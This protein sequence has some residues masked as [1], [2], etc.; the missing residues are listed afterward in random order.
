MVFAGTIATRSRHLRDRVFFLVLSWFPLLCTSGFAQANVGQAAAPPLPLPLSVEWSEAIHPWGDHKLAAD[1]YAVL[2]KTK[3]FKLQFSNQTP[4]FLGISQFQGLPGGYRITEFALT[5]KW[6]TIHAFRSLGFNPRSVPAGQARSFTGAA[7]ELPKFIAGTNLSAYLLR[8]APAARARQPAGQTAAPDG[9][10]IGFAVFRG[11]GKQSRLLAEWVQ[12]HY[13]TASSPSGD[14]SPLSGGLRRG[15]V[16][17]FD[18]ILAKTDLNL[19]LATRGLGL[20]SPAMPVYQPAKRSLRLDVRR[21]LKQHQL[22]Y[23]N[24]YESRQAVPVLQWGFMGVKEQTVR[25]A[26]APRRLPQISASH[27]WS[28]QRAAGRLENE[29]TSRLSLGKTLRRINASLALLRT[30]RTDLQSSC[31]VL[32]RYTAAADATLRIRQDTQ[33]HVRYEMGRLAQPAWSQRL[34][35]SG[36]EL[37]T[38][39]R[40]WTD[41]LS[42]VPVFTYRRQ[43]DRYSASALSAARI[44]VAAQI[45][46]PRRIPGSDLLVNFASQHLSS[47]GSPGQGSREM[48]LRWNFKR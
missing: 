41:R 31:L 2:A 30:S 25:W 5:R 42:L 47:T 15:L 36:L 24:Q 19:T 43:A 17:K 33:L 10:Q 12:T 18:G 7:L 29:E 32:D 3:N 11:I 45:R 1:R 35:T 37:D 44:A 39:F 40:L 16:V 13:G 48:S 38:R 34:S 14:R 26:Y 20:A 23:S 4:A 46:L 27:T 21:K 8:A 22:Q 28:R 9:S 6:G